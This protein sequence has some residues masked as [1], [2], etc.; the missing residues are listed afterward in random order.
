MPSGLI[1]QPAASQERS[2]SG[3]SRTTSLQ[4]A[5]RSKLLRDS[6][7]ITLA[8][9]AALLP[10]SGKA[11]N[12][13]D[14]LFVWSAQHIVQHPLDPFGFQ[15][16]WDRT[17]APMSTVTMNP[18]LACYYAALIGWMGGWS[19]RVL[20]IGFLLPAIAMALGTYA[21]ARRLTNLPLFATA[22]AL[23][24]PGI[25]V[26][27]TSV[28]CDTLMLAFWLWAIVFWI[29]GTA[30]ENLKMYAAASLLIG[31]AAMTKYYGLSLLPLL[32]AYSL[33]KQRRIGKWCWFLL[34][35]VLV[36]MWY[37]FWTH[38]LYRHGMLGAAIRFAPERIFGNA[39]FIPIYFLTCASF[40]GGCTASAILLAPVLWSWKRII[41]VLTGG[42]V[43]GLTMLFLLGG[44]LASMRM[45]I[46]LMQHW[47]ASSVELLIFISAG[48]SLLALPISDFVRNRDGESL[49][50]ALWVLGTFF[51][52]AFINWSI[53]ARSVLPLIPA[54]GILIT[55]RLEMSPEHLHL[56]RFAIGLGIL[57]S[58]VLSMLVTKSDVALAESTKRAAILVSERTRQGNGQVVFQGHWGF[59]YYMQQRGLRPFDFAKCTLHRGDVLIIPANAAETTALPDKYRDFSE[60]ISIPLDQHVITERWQMGSGFYGAYFGPL[61]F[62]FGSIPDER[63]VLEHIGTE[64]PPSRWNIGAEVG[65]QNE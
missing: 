16:L 31:A 52:A 36:L 9:I 1:R 41:V 17:W 58:V 15:V 7:L 50:L 46:V 49:L 26:S 10:F 53:N 42:A 60:E 56:H 65:S 61:P 30:P 4:R 8:T 64:M 6:T 35:P 32:F 33:L 20:H 51:F 63:Y 24:T 11:F 29:K 27:A 18:P 22:A 48:I 40:V 19:E 37:Q 13:D 59:Q 45:G 43:L 34:P 62:A 25:I 44:R 55:R 14:P 39:H 21:L 23:L 38:A 3:R 2:A 47:K 54:A 57:G 5:I 12:I 28:M